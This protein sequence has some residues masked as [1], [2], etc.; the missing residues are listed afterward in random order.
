[1]AKS[2]YEKVYESLKKSIQKTDTSNFEGFFAFQFTV[3]GDAAG[4]FYAKFEKG[5]GKITVE[6]F[7]YK[8]A[9]ATFKAD[10]KTFTALVEGKTSPADAIASGALIVEGNEAGCADIFNAIAPK[11]AKPAKAAPAKKAAAAKKAPAKKAPAK[12]AEAPKTEAKKIEAP[13]A[14]AKKI[15]APKVEAVKTEAPKAAKTDAAKRGRKPA[16]KK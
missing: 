3:T 7:D 8:D 10:A 9:T 16:A 4:T 13:K 1:M 12:K 11:A 5:D 6:N 14:E 2:A 15:E